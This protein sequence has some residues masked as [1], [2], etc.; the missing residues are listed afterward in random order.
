MTNQ[1][2]V[3]NA[4]KIPMYVFL[5]LAAV[6][7]GFPFLWMVLAATNS[8]IDIVRAR[9]FIGMNTLVN[10]HNLVTTRPLYSAFINSLRITLVGTVGSLII[11]SLAG[12]GFQVYKSKGKDTLMTVLLLSMMVPFSA[13]MIPLYRMFSHWK[14]LNTTAAIVL[15][16]LS[17]AFLIF[18]FRQN[19]VNFPLEIVQAARVDGVGEFSIFARIYCPVMMPTFAAAG[20]IT[21]MGAWNNYLWPLVV[22]LKEKAQTLPLVLVS[23]TLGYTTDYG[24]LMLAVS[25][26]TIPTVIIFF[27]AQKQ[28]VNGILG[29]VK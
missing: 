3:N 12:Y 1:K 19:T 11:C 20:V 10:W 23:I 13:T 5:F 7:S 27:A 15:P 26:A 25:I 14:L 6:I 2:M 24:L 18:F 22:L 17:T 8:S 4:H 28:F 16:S 9:F 29:S 21:F